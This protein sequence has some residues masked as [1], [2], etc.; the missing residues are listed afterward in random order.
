VGKLVVD[1]GQF[2]HGVPTVVA[3]TIVAVVSSGV[4]RD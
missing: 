2:D 4:G 1:L 3:E